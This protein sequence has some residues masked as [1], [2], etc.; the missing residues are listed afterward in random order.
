MGPLLDHAVA[1]IFAF[2]LVVVSGIIS[3][4]ILIFRASSAASPAEATSPA[5][6]ATITV[7]AAIVVAIAAAIVPGIAF[8]VITIAAVAA[9]AAVATVRAPTIVL[10][11]RITAKLSLS[12]SRHLAATQ[13][14]QAA[15][16]SQLQPTNVKEETPDTNLRAHSV[17]S[18][19][20]VSLGRGAQR[21]VAAHDSR[22]GLPG[23]AARLLEDITHGVGEGF[24]EVLGSGDGPSVHVVH[25]PAGDHDFC[26]VVIALPLRDRLGWEE[27][28]QDEER[29]GT[30]LVCFG[31]KLV[32]IHFVWAGSGEVTVARLVI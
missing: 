2:A 12:A 30:R 5:T 32:G 24:V 6:V 10:K 14:K 9:V 3:N 23:F 8:I 7:A 28:V 4:L 27:A 29:I 26:H 19:E 1:G 21:L 31:D 18:V 20:P 25:L 13:L 17:R 22:D 15:A 16:T 11:I